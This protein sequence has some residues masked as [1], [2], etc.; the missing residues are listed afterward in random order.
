MPNPAK[1]D[2]GLHE[3]CQGAARRAWR[4]SIYGRCKARPVVCRTDSG[5]TGAR[6]GF[7]C[8][9]YGGLWPEDR[10]WLRDIRGAPVRVWK[11]VANSS[12]EAERGLSSWAT[13]AAWEIAEQACFQERLGLHWRPIHGSA[14]NGCQKNRI[15][16][17]PGSGTCCWVPKI[18]RKEGRKEGRLSAWHAETKCAHVLLVQWTQKN[19]A[20][21]S[22]W[23]APSVKR[24]FMQRT[25]VSLSI[26]PG[27]HKESSTLTSKSQTRGKRLRSARCETVLWM[28]RFSY[29]MAR[30]AVPDLIL[31]ATPRSTHGSKSTRITSWARTLSFTLTKWTIRETKCFWNWTSRALVGW[32]TAGWSS[33]CFASMWFIT[34]G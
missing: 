2:D 20:I 24:L 10:S 6:A 34:A 11:P 17:H 13:R 26:A 29:K 23:P 12:I 14:Q 32:S 9:L 33:W 22:S 7:G 16:P 1:G 30:I 21:R 15:K 5:G 19:M 8:F 27:T 3:S 31:T 4:K 18:G 28:A 25:V